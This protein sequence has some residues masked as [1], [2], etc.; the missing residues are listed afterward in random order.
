MS[1]LT[2]LVGCRVPVQQAPMGSVSTPDLAVAVADAGGIGT[3][4]AFG[5]S[6][7]QV[8]GRVS[9]AASRTGGVL[10]VNFLSDRI[11]PDAVVAA[12]ERVR[13]VDFYWTDPRADLVALVHD[14]GALACW[15]VGSVEEARAAVDA[16]CD[17]LAVQGLEAG[18]HV[19]GHTALLP[20]LAAVLDEVD[21]PVLAAGGISH[22]RSV[23]AVQ[24]AGAA[25]VRVGTSFIATDESGAHPAYKQALVDAEAGSTQVT[26][27]FADCPLCATS[28]RA[29]VLRSAIEAAG[30]AEAVV[31]AA[32]LGGRP[33][34]VPRGHGMPPD[35]TAT[36][37]VHAMALY[38]GEG[39]G[40]VR[41]V[42]PAAQVV[43]ELS[44]WLD[45]GSNGGS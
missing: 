25:G 1:A 36:G 10:A 12:A 5:L 22:P 44:G 33:F 35:A 27:A 39:I 9:G 4:S 3:L 13:I 43:A 23:A 32:V 28:P 8:A 38:A 34:E 6:V 40:L 41:A 31:G 14:T 19:R 17:L 30:A 2:E 26:D 11:D 20:L 37:Q 7:E 15:Q 45:A 24:A 29:R 18:G 16:G 42:V 21:V